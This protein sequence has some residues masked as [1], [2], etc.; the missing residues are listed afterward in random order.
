MLAN[1]LNIAAPALAGLAMSVFSFLKYRAY[2]RT[3]Q[4]IVDKLGVDGLKNVDVIVPPSNRAHPAR[5]NVRPGEPPQ[6][7]QTADTQL[8][9]AE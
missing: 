8:R 5:L 1:I 2:I 3:I 9:E 6:H 4:H 7:V